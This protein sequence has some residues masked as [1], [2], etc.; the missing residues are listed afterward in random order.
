MNIFEP[1][2]SRRIQLEYTY[3]GPNNEL[4]ACGLEPKKVSPKYTPVTVDFNPFDYDV[5]M[6]GPSKYSL[7]NTNTKFRLKP[8]FLSRIYDVTDSW[9]ANRGVPPPGIR[10]GDSDP[11]CALVISAPVMDKNEFRRILKS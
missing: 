2:V 9:D 5:I 10:A 11:S 3:F 8:A 1:L 6:S 4:F 7:S